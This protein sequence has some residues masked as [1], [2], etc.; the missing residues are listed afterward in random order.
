MGRN[1]GGAASDGFIVG[2]R[3]I[4]SAYYRFSDGSALVVNFNRAGDSQRG[5]V[6]HSDASR[7]TVTTKPGDVILLKGEPRTVA[8]V[9]A[10]RENTLPADKLEECADATPSERL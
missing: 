8:S 6:R 7:R 10:Y 3:I 2:N 4:Y 9:R 5:N 1:E